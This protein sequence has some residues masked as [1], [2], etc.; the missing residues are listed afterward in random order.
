MEIYLLRQLCIHAWGEERTLLLA[1]EKTKLQEIQDNM[2]I[3]NLF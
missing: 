2:Q 3:P 1:S